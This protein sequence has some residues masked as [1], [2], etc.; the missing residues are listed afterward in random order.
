MQE[1][2]LEQKVNQLNT[3]IYITALGSAYMK[4]GEYPKAI[5]YFKRSLRELPYDESTHYNLGHCYLKT[6][7]LQKAIYHFSMAL[8]LSEQQTA[9]VSM[10]K[11]VEEISDSLEKAK[12]L[13]AAQKEREILK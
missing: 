1:I 11:Q 2:K 3:G 9:R 10:Q 13:L 12:L 6:W 8:E 4:K 7:S 5:R